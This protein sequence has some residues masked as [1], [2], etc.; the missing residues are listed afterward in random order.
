MKKLEFGSDATLPQVLES[1]KASEEEN[2]DLNLP[3]D[4]QI[5]T[6]FINN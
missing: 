6:N 3:E 5:F 1:I 4:S 2:I